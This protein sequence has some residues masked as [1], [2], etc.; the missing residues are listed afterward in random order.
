MELIWSETAADDLEQ[1]QNYIAEDNIDAAINFI[2]AIFEEV[3]KIPLQPYRGRKV[4]EL[5]KEEYR[6]IIFRKYRI[7]YRVNE[8]AIFI[9]AI[10]HSRINF[11]TV[12]SKIYGLI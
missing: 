5:L 3:E 8:T 10:I 2:R 9:L 1:V 7:M 6:E 4:P 12:K 11:N